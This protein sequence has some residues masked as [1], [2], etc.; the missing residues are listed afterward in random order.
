[1][2]LKSKLEGDIV[3]IS[4]QPKVIASEYQTD[5][6]DCTLKKYLDAEKLSNSLILFP[7]YFL[8][9][10][11]IK[12]RNNTFVKYYNSILIYVKEMRKAT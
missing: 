12:K 1:M 10:V 9:N 6:A 8:V 2:H 4:S 11:Q 5:N 7:L 3:H